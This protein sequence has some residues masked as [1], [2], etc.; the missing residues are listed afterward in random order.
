MMYAKLIKD[1]PHPKEL[2]GEY[3]W[4]SPLPFNKFMEENINETGVSPTS[5]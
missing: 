4:N 1:K 3:T 2:V 5:F